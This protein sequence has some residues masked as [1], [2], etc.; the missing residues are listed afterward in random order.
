M[1][2]HSKPRAHHYLPKCLLKGFAVVTK[3][4]K[5]IWVYTKGELYRKSTV[6]NEAHERDFYAG[7]MAGE[8]RHDFEVMLSGIENS[9]APV[10]D[11]IRRDDNYEITNPDRVIL[12]IFTALM[13][14]RV[15]QGREFLD[16]LAVEAAKKVLHTRAANQTLFSADY[17]LVDTGEGWQKRAE[18]FRQDVL[19]GRL[20]ISQTSKAFNLRYVIEA[21]SMLAPLLGEMEWRLWRAHPG[22]EFISGDN[23][24]I[25][26]YPTKPG[27]AVIGSGFGLANTEIYFPLSSHVSLVMKH[28][29]RKSPFWMLPTLEELNLA[30]MTAATKR[31]Y[32]RSFSKTT[33]DLFQKIGCQ[34]RYGK[35]AFVAGTRPPA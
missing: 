11:R 34:L 28:H 31:V 1:T 7:E 4:R 5:I 12:A 33:D 14:Y 24:V 29:H 23:P 16:Q 3:K 19:H 21:T 9:V 20:D 6:E 25:S 8:K 10:L 22:Q 13:F 26:L 17:H 30:L 2:G 32:A 18:E 15:H 35:N 27:R